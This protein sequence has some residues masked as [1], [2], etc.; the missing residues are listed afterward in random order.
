MRTFSATLDEVVDDASVWCGRE[1]L[2]AV[3]RRGFVLNS[4]NEHRQEYEWAESEGLVL[5][6]PRNMVDQ[7]IRERLKRELD[8]AGLPALTKVYL[9]DVHEIACELHRSGITE[10]C[11]TCTVDL[12]RDKGHRV[13]DHLLCGVCHQG[14][15]IGKPARYRGSLVPYTVR[16]KDEDD[17]YRLQLVSRVTRWALSE[18]CDDRRHFLRLIRETA[19]S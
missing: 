15:R 4:C 8:A 13:E 5:P 2:S 11:W 18:R 17:V 14:A 10:R 19:E 3:E 9:Y 12:K 6:N 7:I 1:Y 16:E